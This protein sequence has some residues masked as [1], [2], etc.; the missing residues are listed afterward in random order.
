MYGAI[1]VPELANV[2]IY[3]HDITNRNVDPVEFYMGAFHDFDLDGSWNGFDTYKYSDAYGIAYGT[4]CAPA[5]TGTVVYGVG[6]I[7]MDAMIGGRT[8]DANQTMWEGDYV[9]LD[10]LYYWATNEPGQT[11]QAGIEIAFPCDPASESDDRDLWAAFLG[12]TLGG[13]E[14]YSMGT[15]FFGYEVADINDDQFFFDMATL[16]NQMSGFDRGDIDGS[17]VVDLADVVALWNMVNAGGAG[18][19]FQHMADV[20]ASGGAPD[21]A[22][23]A[24]LANYY[25]CNGPAP[26]GDWAMPDICP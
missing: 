22:D 14:T 6:T 25:F 23:V 8:C 7:P 18:P 11:A 12:H 16:I 9:G 20:D 17:G 5:Y 3:R 15:Y 2:V 13:G 10:S 19:L 21:N 4:P 26:S 24:Y 1:D